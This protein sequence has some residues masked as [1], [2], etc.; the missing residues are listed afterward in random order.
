LNSKGEYEFAH[1]QRMKMEI[2]RCSW[3]TAE[4]NRHRQI[5]SKE[6]IWRQGKKAQRFMAAAT[7]QQFRW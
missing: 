5:V 2:S 7:R 3:K 4:Q 6:W 1:Y